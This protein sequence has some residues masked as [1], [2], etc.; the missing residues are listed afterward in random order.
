MEERYR[1]VLK[2]V[3]GEGELTFLDGY[4]MERLPSAPEP[5]RGRRICGRLLGVKGR[6]AVFQMGGP[7]AVNVRNL[8]GRV[9]VRG[10]RRRTL[11]E[12]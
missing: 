7:R 9:L 5:H 12:F 2:A 1:R 6:Y 10:G 4:P 8:L 3:G 11:E